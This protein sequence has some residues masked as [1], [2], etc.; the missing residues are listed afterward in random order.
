MKQSK[1]KIKVII[2]AKIKVKITIKL[3]KRSTHMNKTRIKGNIILN[4]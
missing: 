2:K 4:K 1:R 3:K